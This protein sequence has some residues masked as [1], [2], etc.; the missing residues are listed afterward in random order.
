VFGQQPDLP[1]DIDPAFQPAFDALAAAVKDGEDEL[2]RR[3]LAGIMARHPPEHLREFARGYERILDGRAL[4]R[5]LDLALVSEPVVGS[6]GDFRLVLEAG[7]GRTEPVVLRLPPAGLRRTVTAIDPS[8]NESRSLTTAFTPA[9]ED[10][11]VPPGERVRVRLLDY[12]LELGGALAA[13]ERWTLEMHAGVFE[14]GGEELPAQDPVVR[15]AERTRLAPFLPPAPVEPAEL[16]RYLAGDELYL[17]ALIERAVRIAP[18][19]REEALDALTPV[20]L[21]L[22][23][24]RPAR[25][26]SA[27]PALRWLAR[28][29]RQDT[30]AAWAAWFAARRESAEHPPGA[31]DL[32]GAGGGA[33]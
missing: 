14:V 2:A 33:G 29:G 4:G 32:P 16:A 31:L 11:S 12:E 28:T 20:V 6:A 23:Q 30:P 8:G 15:A 27:A 26:E 13:R 3:I 1:R 21:R 24:E 7:H 5:E 25:L 9:V 22:E 18:E 10:L 17:P 19:R